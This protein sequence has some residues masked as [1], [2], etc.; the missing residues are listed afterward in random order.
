[1]I[2][3]KVEVT[4]QDI[5]NGVPGHPWHCPI[6][7][8]LSRA[9]GDCGLV[10]EYAGVGYDRVRILRRG[11]SDLVGPLPI[12]M[13]AWIRDWDVEQRGTPIKFEIELEVAT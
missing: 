9:L 10:F 4:Q 3:V 13:Q 6:A 7:R 12:F 2:T 1:M 8:A 11:A 5:E